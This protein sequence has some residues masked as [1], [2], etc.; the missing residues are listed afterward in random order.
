MKKI[1]PIKT[2]RTKLKVVNTLSIYRS[3][4]PYL[5]YGEI[6][7]DWYSKVTVN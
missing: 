4:K 6:E 3:L 7:T 5:Q 2:V 1:A